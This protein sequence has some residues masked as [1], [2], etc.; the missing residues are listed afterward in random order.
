MTQ[1][2][3]ESAL[4]MLHFTEKDT[5]KEPDKVHRASARS[6]PGT[7]ESALWSG[8]EPH[9][10]TRMCSPT[11]K[12]EILYDPAIPLLGIYP[13]KTVVQKD[14]RTPVFIVAQR[15]GSKLNVHQKMKG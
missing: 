10:S 5:N 1:K 7:G 4:L 3:L 2:T 15:R 11:Q 13:D 8:V 12:L 6:I 9:S 14:T